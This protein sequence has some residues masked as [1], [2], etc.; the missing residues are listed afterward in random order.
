MPVAARIILLMSSNDDRNRLI[1]SHQSASDAFDRAL[2]TLSAGSLALSIAFVRDIAPNPESVWMVKTSWV[3]MGLALLLIMGSFVMSV[4]VHRRLIDC[5]DGDRRYEDEPKWTRCV[6]SYL[7][8]LAGLVFV[9]GA[10]FLIAF[11]MTN[12]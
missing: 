7:N 10:G 3:L 12:L 4:E 11:A 1:A 6:V 9:A 5:I 8:R 2:M